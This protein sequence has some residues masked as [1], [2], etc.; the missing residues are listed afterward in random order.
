MFPYTCAVVMLVT[1]DLQKN[2][3][4]CNREYQAG[5][6]QR[7][8]AP[9][10]KHKPHTATFLVMLLVNFGPHN[11]NLDL[12]IWWPGASFIPLAPTSRPLTQAPTSWPL[13]Y[14]DP[15]TSRFYFTGSN[16]MTIDLLNDN[17]WTLTPQPTYILIR[18]LAHLFH[19][20]VVPDFDGFV[21]G[22][23]ES[24]ICPLNTACDARR[25]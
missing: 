6:C 22:G 24:L 14:F 1:G 21:Q 11:Y 17:C 8:Q 4:I 5:H 3:P 2:W 19:A 12:F 25:M 7:N 20:V 13:T 10:L 9:P 15:M 18:K 23:R 16:L